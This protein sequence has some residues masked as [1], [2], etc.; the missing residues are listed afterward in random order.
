MKPISLPACKHPSADPGLTKSGDNLFLYPSGKRED[1]RHH[2]YPP[3]EKRYD[4]TRYD[5]TTANSLQQ[6][7]ATISTRYGKRDTIQYDTTT[8]SKQQ[9]TAS[10]STHCGKRERSD[11]KR[12]HHLYPLWA[13]RYDSTRQAT[14][15][16][17]GLVCNMRI[18]FYRLY[19]VVSEEGKWAG[20]LEMFSKILYT[21]Q[22]F[23]M[24]A[25]VADSRTF[26]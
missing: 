14:R 7:S 21:Y 24:L 10:N 25:E 20:V 9:P 2:L 15:M 12:R 26:L 22:R 18:T 19:F 5:T 4:T 1:F 8:S 17:R 23:G 11:T 16:S 13:K 3:W 6:P